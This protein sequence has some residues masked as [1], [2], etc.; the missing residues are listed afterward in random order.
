MK[1]TVPSLQEIKMNKLMLA[2]FGLAFTTGLAGFSTASMAEDKAVDS[3]TTAVTTPAKA[4][5]AKP[6]DHAATK[7][8]VKPEAKP[9][10]KPA[11]DKKDTTGK[12]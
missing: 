6:A 11:T 2:L 7:P 4:P 10:A 1:E 8:T 5:V 12:N 9:A 3:K